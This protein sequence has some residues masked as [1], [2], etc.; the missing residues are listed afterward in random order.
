MHNETRT[1]GTNGRLQALIDRRAALD[2][3]MRAEKEKQKAAEAKREDK[4]DR[5]VG[6]ALRK[7]AARDPDFAL[8]LAGLVQK[9]ADALDE[10]ARNFLI[11]N[12][13]LFSRLNRPEE[14]VLKGGTEEEAWK[15]SDA[16]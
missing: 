13:A 7:Q 2:A 4:L 1:N 12:D 16:K 14:T 6:R 10:S 9:A 5:I 11:T 8:S 15:S 3:A